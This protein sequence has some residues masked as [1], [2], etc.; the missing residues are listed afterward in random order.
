[1][2]SLA[3]RAGLRASGFRYLFHRRGLGA[4]PIQKRY[5][6]PGAWSR[7]R[8]FAAQRQNCSRSPTWKRR[9]PGV[10]VLPP[11]PSYELGVNNMKLLAVKVVTGA[12]QFG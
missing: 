9:G 7:G 4:T 2:S 1:M 12:P 10:L 3:L 11:P 6:K 5:P 8:A